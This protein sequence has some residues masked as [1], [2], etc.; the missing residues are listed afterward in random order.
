MGGFGPPS[1]THSRAL[2]LI[3]ERLPGAEVRYAWNIMDFGYKAEE[4]LWMVERGLLTLGYMTTS[5]LTARV[6]ELELL[7]LPYLFDTRAKAHAAMDGRLGRWFAEL[8]E[9]Q[10]P[11]YRVLGWFENGFRHYSN[12]LR[13]VRSP[14]DMKG[15]RVRTLPSRIHQRTHELLGAVA[16]VMDLKPGIEAMKTGEV[17]TQENPLTNT[18]DY[19]AHTL[20]RHHTLTGH[21]YLSRAILVHRPSFDAFPQALQENLRDAVEAA[22][23]AQREMAEK[24]EAL[25]RKAIIA[26]GGEIVELSAEERAAFM[27]AVQPLHDEARQRFSEGFSLLAT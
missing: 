24:E 10:V 2:K 11:A 14:A 3:G 12:K 9:K 18:L 22:V 15:L 8:I 7:D 4:V 20:H 23:P 5:Y 25:A 21:M 26:A 27:R 17:D 13:P 1:T 16:C 6:P 19:G